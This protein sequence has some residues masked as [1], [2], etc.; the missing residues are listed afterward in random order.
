MSLERSVSDAGS[1]VNIRSATVPLDRLLPGSHILLKNP[2]QGVFAALM[3]ALLLVMTEETYRLVEVPGIGFGK[4]ESMAARESERAHRRP[5][6][7]NSSG[8]YS[9]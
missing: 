6:V 1:I 8:R 4:R 2:I 7:Q 9:V 3:L 5:H